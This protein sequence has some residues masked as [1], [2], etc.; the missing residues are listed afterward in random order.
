MQI[1]EKKHE[2]LHYEFAVTVPADVIAKTIDEELLSLGKKVKISGFRPGKVPLDVLR[3]R[4]QKEVMGEVLQNTINKA[5]RDVIDERK[6]R[7]ALQPDIKVTSFED[8]K[9][10]TFDMELDVLPDLPEIKYDAIKVPEYTYEVPADEVEEGLKRIA[11]SRSHLHDKDGEAAK[12]DVATIDFI[13]RIDGEAFEGGTANDV[14]LELGGG[15]FIPGFEDQIVGAKAGDKVNVEVNFPENYHS[16]D[17]AGKPAVFETTVKKVSEKH[18]PELNDELAKGLGFESIDALR[19][20]VK[21]QI[22]GDYAGAARNKAK[23]ALFD[24]LDEEVKFDIPA[25]MTDMEFDNVWKQVEEAKK[26]GDP[27]MEGK[28]DD[29]LKDEYKAIS[30]RRVRLGI[31]LAE[32]GRV[33]SIQITN[34]EL[35]AAVMQQARQY[36]GQEDKIFE[37]YRSNPGQMEQLRGPI[38]E[39]KAV[40][41][42]LEKV[43][44]EE[45]KVDDAKSLF[46]DDEP[47]AKESKPKKAAKAKK[48]AAEKAPKKKAS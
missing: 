23:K 32:I 11:E 48:P 25:K 47:E 42:L 29:E 33:N 43:S 40:D 31:L 34:E 22:D 38:L 2:G 6:L 5:S 26:Q 17:L 46:L 7:P 20:A 45:V 18:A 36:P 28:S 13:G 35:S 44:R 8:G 16:A 39:E 14:P 15:Q 9:D 10:L 24:A 27:A 1:T 3:Q 4:Y 41:F 30:A 19:D 21:G 37:F 12:G